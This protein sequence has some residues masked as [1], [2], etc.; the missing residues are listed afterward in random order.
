ME[1]TLA[2]IL[3]QT[4]QQNSLLNSNVDKIT[5]IYSGAVEKGAVVAESARTA[6]ESAALVKSAQEL[7][8]LTAQ[9]NTTK[10]ALALGT[11]MDDVSEIVTS[12]AADM[13]DSYS[14]ARA[15]L[16]T[17]R[18]N[19]S[20]SLLEDPVGW[21]GIQLGGGDAA[22][23]SYT[24]NKNIYEASS[25]HLSAINALT[26]QTA[27]TQAAIAETRTA[28]SVEAAAK[29]LQAETDAKVAAIEQQN[30]LLNVQGL[31]AVS[32]LNQAQLA[33]LYN[34]RQAIQSDK[35]FAM[36]Q[37][38]H[39]M[40]MKEAR[41][42]LAKAEADG[43]DS[44]LVRWTEQ[45]MAVLTGGKAPKLSR[46]DTMTLIKMKEPMYAEAL[47][48]GARAE[49]TGGITIS[50]NS[51]E[52]AVIVAKTKASLPAGM[53][54]VT[55][56]LNSA[57]SDVM[58]GK[59]GKV[60]DTKDPKAITAASGDGINNAV[61]RMAANVN[62]SDPKVN[63]YA[64][65]PLKSIATTNPAVAETPLFSRVL[66]P[67]VQT[68]MT[69][70]EPNRIISL[71]LAGIKRGDITPEEAIT[72]ITT[73]TRAGYEINNQLRQYTAVGIPAQVG[74]KTKIERPDMT[75][76]ITI[77]MANDTAVGREISRQLMMARRK[78]AGSMKPNQPW[79][80]N[81]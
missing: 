61:R 44:A 81:P 29:G 25:S 45:G 10:A 24:A 1:P 26:T 58:T 23:A 12:V 72:G 50:P 7:G 63:I 11:K 48:I 21:L 15:D 31:D 74:Y 20:T 66:A 36:Q 27:Q 4:A 75:M 55:Y 28:A 70:F 49:M 68:G 59:A 71:A 39:A 9:N 54:P 67:Q 62:S 42:R 16:E 41:A 30:L 65:P 77:D 73:L 79:G 40:A 38:S 43:D 8:M 53:E 34:A 47:A 76:P 69:D 35:A 6:G 46:K 3:T 33:N 14:R 13:Q 64:L 80:A 56:L 22:I 17:I 51:G 32:K 78:D 52:A 19:Q 18:E 60:V 5:N 37:E 57:V 2:D